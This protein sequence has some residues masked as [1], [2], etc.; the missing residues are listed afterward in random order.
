MFVG[1]GG[2]VRGRGL[3]TARQV[4]LMSQLAAMVMLTMMLVHVVVT[5]VR[6][7]KFRHMHVSISLMI[8]RP[9]HDAMLTLIPIL[10]EHIEV[11]AQRVAYR[12]SRG[13]RSVVCER[14]SWPGGRRGPIRIAMLR[15]ELPGSR[16][17][18]PECTIC[19]LTRQAS[20]K[21]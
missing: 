12:R 5:V 19:H 13:R 20:E 21:D 10:R 1:V 2:E 6:L 18:E 4:V 17:M 3:E 15:K 7:L 8:L 14:S 11:V 16:L 9:V